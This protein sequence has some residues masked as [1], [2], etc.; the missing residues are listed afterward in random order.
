MASPKWIPHEQPS[1]WAT[2]QLEAAA[3]AN[4]ARICVQYLRAYVGEYGHLLEMP[5]LERIETVIQQWG[6][7]HG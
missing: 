5:A 1:D 4:T 7:A 2:Q 6:S 3:R